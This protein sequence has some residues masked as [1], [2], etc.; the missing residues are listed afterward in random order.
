MELENTNVSGA[1][2]S[3]TQK[4]GFHSFQYINPVTADVYTYGID[5]EKIRDTITVSGSIVGIRMSDIQELGYFDNRFFAYYE[6]T[7]LF[8]R[9]KRAGKRIIYNP[10]VVIF[11]KDGESTKDK[12]YF[13]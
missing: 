12:K 4:D 9:Y 8:A 10:E 7:D 13:Y 1:K 5:D 11:H 2:S 6:E 3:I